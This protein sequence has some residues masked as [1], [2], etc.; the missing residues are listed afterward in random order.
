[1]REVE[2]L[3]VMKHEL[4]QLGTRSGRVSYKV[5]YVK[6]GR[7]RGTEVRRYMRRLTTRDKTGELWWV[8]GTVV[9]L[10]GA[11]LLGG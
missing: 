10:C 2:Q 8:Q 5:R 7:R 4:E 11:E 9:R 1:M 3:G 6:V